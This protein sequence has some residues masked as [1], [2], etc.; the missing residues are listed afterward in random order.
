MPSSA[1]RCELVTGPCVARGSASPVKECLARSIGSVQLR[2]SRREGVSRLKPFYQRSLPLS[3]LLF[4]LKFSS[5]DCLKCIPVTSW[6]FAGKGKVTAFITYKEVRVACMVLWGR[7]VH[8]GQQVARVTARPG[9]PWPGPTSPHLTHPQE[10]FKSIG[11]VTELNV[12][13]ELRWNSRC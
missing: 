8:Q 3:I 2:H 7:S 10:L 11:S 13:I 9:L 4:D 12:M 5:T 6:W 1:P